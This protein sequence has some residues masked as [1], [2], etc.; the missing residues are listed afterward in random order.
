MSANPS[1]RAKK[2]CVPN[3]IGI[4]N[5]RPYYSTYGQYHTDW[6]QSGKKKKKKQNVHVCHTISSGQAQYTVPLREQLA[7]GNGKCEE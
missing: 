1:G 7:T 4:T 6:S 5:S 3:V 2:Y